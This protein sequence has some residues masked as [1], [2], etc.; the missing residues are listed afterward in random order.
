MSTPGPRPIAKRSRFKDPGCLFVLL[1]AVALVGGLILLWQGH[2][3][4]RGPAAP[5]A[6]VDGGAGR[7]TSAPPAGA[8]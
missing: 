3:R 5:A 1:T 2:R 8:R 4:A 7:G 6:H